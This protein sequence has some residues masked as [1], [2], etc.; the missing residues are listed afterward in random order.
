[1]DRVF[2]AKVVSSV[3]ENIAVSG[4]GVALLANTVG[5][6]NRQ[7]QRKL[8]ALTGLAPL[9]LIRRL[10]LERA[11]HLF[12]QQ[13]GTVSEIAYACGFESPAYFT[14]LFR[15]RFGMPPNHYRKQKGE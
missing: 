12:Q 3:H 8:A 15:K 1:M 14:K 6:S 5:L 4:F 2:L 11:A 10:R 13:T 9:A 7:L